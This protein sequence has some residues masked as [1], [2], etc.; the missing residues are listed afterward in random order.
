MA[1]TYSNKS[2]AVSATHNANVAASAKT[3]TLPDSHTQPAARTSA[4]RTGTQ[5]LCQLP[6][7]TVGRFVYEPE[8]STANNPILRRVA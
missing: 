1:E 6:D 7:G 2:L 3:L 5:V 4:M 8:L